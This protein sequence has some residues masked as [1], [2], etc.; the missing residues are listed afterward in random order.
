M[1]ISKDAFTPDRI[2]LEQ[3]SISLELIWDLADSLHIQLNG[4]TDD[5]PVWNCTRW[6]RTAQNLCKH[7]LKVTSNTDIVDNIQGRLERMGR[8]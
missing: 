8:A 3:V 6:N 4:F 2:H 7:S 1:T 5:N